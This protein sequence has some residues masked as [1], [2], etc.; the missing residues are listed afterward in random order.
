MHRVSFCCGEGIRSVFGMLGTSL[1]VRAYVRACVTFVLRTHSNKEK[2][3]LFVIG[4]VI[5]SKR[6]VI[7]FV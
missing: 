7:S 5:L 4:F 3:L 6:T 1:Y 2:L